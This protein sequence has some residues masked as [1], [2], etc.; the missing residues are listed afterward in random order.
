MKANQ[1]IPNLVER[2][3]K[4][5]NLGFFDALAILFIALK[6]CGVITWSWMWVLAPIW[7]Q[8]IVLVIAVVIIVIIALKKF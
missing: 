1:L 7:I 5:V 4:T 2:E 6:L 8:F 3:I